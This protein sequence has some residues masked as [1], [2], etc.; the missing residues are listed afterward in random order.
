MWPGEQL[1]DSLGVELPIIQAPMAGA[2]GSDLTIAVCEAGGLGSLPCAMLSPEQAR[3]EVARIR[4]QTDAPFNMNFFCHTAPEPD[5]AADERWRE[6]LR[7]FFAE[8]GADVDA[9]G[10]DPPRAGFGES[11]CALVEE[12][13]PPIVSFHFGLPEAALL[14]RVRATGAR[15]LSS[16]NSVDEARWLESRGVDAII[17]QG[18]EAGG[19]QA[20][21]LRDDVTDVSEQIGTFALVPLIAS[22]VS[23]PVIAAGGISDGR[24]IAAA[25]ALGASGV[26]VGSAYLFTEEAQIAPWHRDAL[27]AAANAGTVRTALTNVFSGRPARSIVN[28]LVEEVGPVSADAPAFPTAGSALAP[29]RVLGPDVAAQFTSLW[30]GQAVPLGRALPAGELTRLLWEEAAE[31]AGRFTSGPSQ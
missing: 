28:R 21:F 16:A 2:H 24:G 22:A 14:A 6:R 27:D 5:P 29:L 17:A 30:A 3:S 12:V 15:I 25:F 9:I 31:V 4:E 1:T 20:L 7:P 10:T 23:V 13:R 19:H 26:Q 11:T 8:L 18:A